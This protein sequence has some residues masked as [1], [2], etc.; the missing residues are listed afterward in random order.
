M[1]LENPERNL[2]YLKEK[3]ISDIKIING[4][5][6]FIFDRKLVSG[7]SGLH[8]ENESGNDLSELGVR[9]ETYLGKDLVF[10]A[11]AGSDS[12]E[13]IVSKGVDSIG[14]EPINNKKTSRQIF[15]SPYLDK[16]TEYGQTYRVTGEIL[17]KDLIVILYSS[18]Q[19]V[20]VEDYKY[21][22]KS[23]PKDALAGV[24]LL[25]GKK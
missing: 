24:L 18:D 25:K 4:K 13:Q 6:I 8:V 20:L 7:T 2:A 5:P 16:A 17:D 11:V 9:L 19:L 1:I 21:E 10:R 14:S 23:E 3:G 22:F 15:A 12:T